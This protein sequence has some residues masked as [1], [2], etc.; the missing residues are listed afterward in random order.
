MSNIE[1]DRLPDEV[2][3][4]IPLGEKIY[5]NGK[6]N[7]KSF[8]YHAFGV[9]YFSIYF[10]V[11]ALYSV[12]QIDSSFSFGAFFIKYAPYLISGI[13]AGMILL[14]LAYLSARHTCYVITEKRIVIRTGVA[15]VFLL[16]MPLKNILSIDMKALTKGQG[17]VI[18]KVQSKKRIPYLSCWPS[19]KSG[20]FLEPIPAFRSIRDIEKIG[21]LI[22][23]IAIL[24]REENATKVET[25]TSG[26]VA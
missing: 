10:F 14:F 16:N 18:F 15:L 26:A 4:S 8:G 23:E 9:K 3:K 17:N 25:E 12:S 21:K 7:W 20:S 11:C 22:S 5:W 19:V 13:L 2:G 24:N 1:I 6:P